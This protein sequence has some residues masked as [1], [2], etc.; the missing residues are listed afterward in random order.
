MDYKFQNHLFKMVCVHSFVFNNPFTGRH[1]QHHHKPL[2]PKYKLYI[3][4]STPSKFK[5]SYMG[6]PYFKGL[7][8]K[9]K[10][11]T[12]ATIYVNM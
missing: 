6:V 10:P 1:F 2:L 4:N 11:Y 7:V 8:K 9:V 5:Q 3:V 12:R